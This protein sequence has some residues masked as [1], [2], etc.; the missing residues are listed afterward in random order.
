[1]QRSRVVTA[2][3]GSL[4]AATIAIGLFGCSEEPYP[5]GGKI[6]DNG[7]APGDSGYGALTYSVTGS[8]GDDADDATIVIE[9]KNGM[10]GTDT[11]AILPW[12]NITELSAVGLK[13]SMTATSHASDGEI[14]CEISYANVTIANTAS[15]DHPAVTCEGT[16]SLD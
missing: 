6:F 14:S 11:S 9:P 8:Q 13:V 5:P 10:P 4:L 16:L 7:R 3:V 15:G 2:V 1:M 12:K